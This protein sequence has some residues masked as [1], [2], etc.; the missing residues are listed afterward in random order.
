MQARRWCFTDY[1]VEHDQEFYKKYN[2]NYVIYGKEVCPTTG[3]MHHQGYMEFMS[4]KRLL[5]LKK[6][7]EQ[8]HWTKCNGTQEDN[9]KY[10]SKEGVVTEMGT[11]C[12]QGRRTDM[13]LAMEM[14]ENGSSD[15]EILREMHTWATLHGVEKLRMKLIKER[16]EP[17][18]VIWV[19]GPTGVGK[20]RKANE[21]LGTRD[22]V[23]YGNGFIVGYTGH[24][25]L[26]DDFRGEIPYALLLR[27]LDRYP[28]TINVKGGSCQWS[29]AKICVTSPEHP[30]GCYTTLEDYRQLERRISMIARVDESGEFHVEHGTYVL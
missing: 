29:P 26:M 7:D 5:Q 19:Y 12:E 3:K 23:S 16:T 1:S 22:D 9:V 28:L 11:K 2:A 25:V 24:N 17:P 27:L 20:T 21:W 15:L 6:L 14:I 4:A 10:C 8:I 13:E 30:R 18:V